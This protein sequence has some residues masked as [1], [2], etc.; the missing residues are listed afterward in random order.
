MNCSLWPRGV[1]TLHLDHPNR[2]SSDGTRAEA[3]P[4]GDRPGVPQTSS[5]NPRPP[6][7]MD[8]RDPHRALLRPRG[9]PPHVSRRG[10]GRP[11][12]PQPQARG[13][14]PRLVQPVLDTQ[15]ASE[16]VLFCDFTADAFTSL[17]RED[18]R[19]RLEHGSSRTPLTASRS[20]E[21]HHCAMSRPTTPS[22]RTTLRVEI[23][24][25]QARG[26]EAALE[27]YDADNDVHG[28]ISHTE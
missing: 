13:R 12:G 6:D 18:R 22:N 20:R 27:P 17:A 25:P 11:G 2:K 24:P 7:R 14:P 9:H 8:R 21:R 3:Q 16:K 15:V 1:D 28:P 4:L 23:Q 26:D 19:V 10:A 5:A